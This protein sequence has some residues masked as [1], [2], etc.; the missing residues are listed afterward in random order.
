MRLLGLGFCYLD[1]AAD[2]GENG[3][4]NFHLRVLHRDTDVELCTEDHGTAL[5]RR[6][7]AAGKTAVSK[8]IG[9]K[10]TQQNTPRRDE[11]AVT[12]NTVQ[13]S[14]DMES[15]VVFSMEVGQFERQR[16]DSDMA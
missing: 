15:M 5:Q 16:D 4:F 10:P 9:H 3:A 8:P 13:H 1:L 7:I 11:E 2:E 12:Y 14:S 6:N